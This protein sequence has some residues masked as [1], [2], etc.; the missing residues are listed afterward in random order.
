MAGET[1]ML[2]TQISTA[3]K[4]QR[5]TLL[6]KRSQMRKLHQSEFQRSNRTAYTLIEVVGV[7]ATLSL[8]TTIVGQIL[9]K[10]IQLNRIAMATVRNELL[11]DS[12]HQQLRDDAYTA[13]N[14][15][16]SA[17]QL[18]M[19]LDGESI[20]YTVEGDLVVRRTVGESDSKVTNQWQ[21]ATGEFELTI[22][23][24]SPIRLLRCKFRWP[25]DS[26]N[27]ESSTEVVE[28]EPCQWCFRLVRVQS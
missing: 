22:E 16:A 4:L 27:T 24:T 7:F 5:T 12:F 1:N 19:H 8:M 2:Q 10:S 6:T 21:I 25:M 9:Y 28:S 11:L 26:T 18:T 15:I 3:S 13:E 14:A 23:A 17:G 20:A